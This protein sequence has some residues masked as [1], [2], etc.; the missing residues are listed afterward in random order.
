MSKPSLFYETYEEWENSA[1]EDFDE[2]ETTEPVISHPDSDPLPCWLLELPGEIRNRIY[3]YVYQGCFVATGNF[4]IWTEQRTEHNAVRNTS[5]V[6]AVKVRDSYYPELEAKVLEPGK[7]ALYTPVTD[8]I[9]RLKE[10]DLPLVIRKELKSVRP[11]KHAVHTGLLFTCRSIYEEFSSVLYFQTVFA[12]GSFSTIN[13]LVDPIK[14]QSGK[15]ALPKR[16]PAALRSLGYVKRICIDCKPRGV[17]TDAASEFQMWRH[18]Q[19]WGESFKVVVQNLP[20]LECIDLFIE[21]PRLLTRGKQPTKLSLD[22]M[23]CESLMP[24]KKCTSLQHITVHLSLEWN[25]GRLVT[26]DTLQ[27]F[28]HF[29][30]KILLGEQ[31]EQAA[32]AI[33]ADFERCAKDYG[34][35]AEA[36]NLWSEHWHTLA[37]W[38]GI[39]LDETSLTRQQ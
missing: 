5:V 1:E 18:Y 16:M 9:A 37:S 21:I 25:P 11:F 8:W 26:A 22:S 30:E 38:N 28:A 12:F 24:L 2:E 13:H 14:P 20:N 10:E 3:E 29:L 27:A 15:K 7:G 34:I 4:R 23:W 33:Q 36:A 35:E 32:K 31:R 6:Q 19:S 17:V 39:R